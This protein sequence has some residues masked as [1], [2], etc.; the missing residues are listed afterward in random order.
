[1]LTTGLSNLTAHAS[2]Y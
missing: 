1:V 2:G